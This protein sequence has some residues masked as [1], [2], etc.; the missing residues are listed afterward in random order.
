MVYIVAEQRQIPKSEALD[1]L[2]IIDI[3]FFANNQ[4]LL[5]FQS[6]LKT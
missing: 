1:L 5:G 4:T 6:N 3:R 2:R